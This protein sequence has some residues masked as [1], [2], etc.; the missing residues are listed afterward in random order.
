MNTRKRISL[1]AV[2]FG[3]V[4]FVGNSWA[5]NGYD[6]GYEYSHQQLLSS[7]YRLS[8]QAGDFRRY[9]REYSYSRNVRRAG[10][11][12]Q[13]AADDLYYQ[14][15][16]GGSEYQL[17][18]AYQQTR[19]TYY[20]LRQYSYGSTHALN[21]LGY[22]LHDVE[23]DYQRYQRQLASYNRRDSYGRGHDRHDRGH[24]NRVGISYRSG[25]YGS[26]FGLHL[27]IR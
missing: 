4:L 2:L 6:D 5:G 15:K 7:S 16:H 20:A 11:A 14:L 22:V 1:V 18:R 26:G 3:A 27:R 24:G 10:Q 21:E 17:Q 12:M 8:E 25:T 23:R 13:T 9:A 19:Q